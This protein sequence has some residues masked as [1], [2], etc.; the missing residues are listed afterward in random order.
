MENLS[1]EIIETNVYPNKILQFGG[2]N[3][4]R[5]FVDWMV[6]VLNEKTDFNA[7]VIIV[8]PKEQ[9]NYKELRQQDGLFT[10]ILEGIKNEKLVEEKKVIDCVQEVVNP[11]L[12]W[13]KYMNITKDENL[14]FIVSNT[15]EAGIK[16][17]PEDK[18]NDKPPQE[19]PA[20]LTILMHQ[21]FQC[22]N[23]NLSKGFIILPC[24]LIENNGE[25]LQK[26]ILEYADLWQL[27]EA[28]KSWILK[29]NLFC[30]TLV[31]RI[32]SGYPKNRIAE[33][34]QELEYH[35]E[36]VVAGEI[37]HS[38]II[39][40]QDSESIKKELPFDK[41]DLNVKF[42]TNLQDYRILKVRI[43]NGAHATL[44]PVGYLSGI[45]KVRESLED[46]SVGKFL[47]EAIFNEICLTL[48]FS[49]KES[50]P[51]CE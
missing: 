24:E 44:V 6:Q 40:T 8:K 2:G 11:Y 3:F 5:C 50:R 16:F 17:N 18:Y 14:R 45:D 46:V 38:W 35:D 33:I 15:T 28:F 23:G 4:L 39:E 13:E 26:T 7:G 51:I 34:E 43:L 22:F 42:V 41:T 32:V 1:R 25:V 21:R 31:D 36:L 49:K 27:G 47:K 48:D 19:F 9:G 10:V 12:E 37:Y 20:K 30:N 29:A